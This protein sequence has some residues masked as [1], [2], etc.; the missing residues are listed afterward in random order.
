MIRTIMETTELKNRP[1]AYTV[2][3]AAKLLGMGHDRAYKLI[4]EEK[5]ETVV[6]GGRHMVLPEVVDRMREEAMA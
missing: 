4:K 6:V 1:L 2:R 5:L 3:E